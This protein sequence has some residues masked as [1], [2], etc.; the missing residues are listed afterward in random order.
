MAGMIAGTVLIIFVTMKL[1]FYRNLAPLCLLI[2]IGISMILAHLANQ[3]NYLKYVVL[4]AAL[5]ILVST[6]MRISRLLP[7]TLYYYDVRSTAERYQA[8]SNKHIIIAGDHITLHENAFYWYSILPRGKCHFQSSNPPLSGIYIAPSDVKVVDKN[9][10][11]LWECE[12]YKC[13]KMGGK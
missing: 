11:L 12:G 13:Y 10:T 2:W 9:A 3:A 4:G 1:P 6:H 8:C 7:D 5:L